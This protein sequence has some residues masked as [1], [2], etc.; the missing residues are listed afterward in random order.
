[1][2]L[3]HPHPSSS[4]RESP[5]R[6][7]GRCR[8]LFSC[9]RPVSGNEPIISSS[10]GPGYKTVLAQ[11][12]RAPDRLGNSWGGLFLLRLLGIPA[13]PPSFAPPAAPIR[14]VFLPQ[15]GSFKLPIRVG[16]S[17][18]RSPAVPP[19][20][21]SGCT[22]LPDL[23]WPCGGAFLRAKIATRALSRGAGR[24]MWLNWNYVRLHPAR[25]CAY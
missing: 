13:P 19:R 9:L 21:S 1:M 24:T 7:G 6:H 14:S 17:V 15:D 16:P 10:A 11:F 2:P 12:I 8:V 22:G 23:C 5:V 18:I 20:T 3:P 4:P 25:R